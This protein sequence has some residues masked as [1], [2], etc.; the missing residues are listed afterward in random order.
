MP[1]LQTYLE[2]FTAHDLRRLSDCFDEKVKVRDPAGQWREGRENALAY[3]TE[4]FRPAHGTDWKLGEL[5]RAQD[6][7]Y[8]P[9][10]FS[11]SGVGA[12]LVA[13][14]LD[15]IHV[16]RDQRIDRIESYGLNPLPVS[17]WLSADASAPPPSAGI[18]IETIAAAK[19]V[20]KRWGGEVWLVHEKAPFAC[21][22]IALKQGFRTSL[23]Y[24]RVKEEANLVVSGKV[25]LHYAATKEVP[26]ATCDISPGTVVH[27]KAGT[28]HRME[29]LTDVLLF[30]VSTP[31]LDD[32]VRLQDDWGRGDG[33]I[34]AEHQARRSRS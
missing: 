31:E 6:F 33:K 30:E 13:E 1:S 5:S 22:L 20:S 19:Q 8:L 23:Q 26:P 10:S 27:V 17:A 25:R 16:T 3:F 4:L 29:A 32:V 12:G 9:Y 18:R 24:H 2:A 11:I 21:K 34:E 7:A 15:R 28:V 14:R